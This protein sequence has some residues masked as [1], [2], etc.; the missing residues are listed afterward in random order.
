MVASLSGIQSVVLNGTRLKPIHSEF[1]EADIGLCFL[2]E[3]AGFSITAM[4]SSQIR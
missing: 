2:M 4:V 1:G 3:F